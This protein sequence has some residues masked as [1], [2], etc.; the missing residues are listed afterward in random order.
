MI[1]LTRLLIDLTMIRTINLKLH[2]QPRL[3]LIPLVFIIPIIYLRILVYSLVFYKRFYLRSVVY[4]IMIISLYYTIL[5]KV[6]FN[7]HILV[8]IISFIINI[9]IENEKQNITY[10][11]FI[12]IDILNQ[13]KQCFI[14]SG[15]HLTYLGIPVV[16]TKDKTYA[17]SQIPYVYTLLGNECKS[18]GTFSSIK[19]SN[20]KKKVFIIYDEHIAYEYIIGKIF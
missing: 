12:D 11:D 15:N 7:S 2:S 3:F 4:M 10:K 5:A 6:N 17:N 16:L 9:Y 19:V 8:S 14:D 20:T 18:Y 13:S 1:Y